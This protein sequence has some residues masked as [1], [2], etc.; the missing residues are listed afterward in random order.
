MISIKSCFDDFQFL[1]CFILVCFYTIV[2]ICYYVQKLRYKILQYEDTIY[3][4]NCVIKLLQKDI[5]D[6]QDNQ[7]NISKYRYAMF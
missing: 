5:I 2:F 4:N 7:N 3:K 6:L 1:Y